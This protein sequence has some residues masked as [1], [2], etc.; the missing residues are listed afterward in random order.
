M[1]DILIKDLHYLIHF[2]KERHYLKSY[3]LKSN[4]YF[5]NL[6]EWLNFLYDN[7]TYYKTKALFENKSL[8][9]HHKLF[10][11]WDNK[12]YILG[13]T[14]HEEGWLWSNLS[15]DYYKLKQLI[16]SLTYVK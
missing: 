4:N 2:L 13:K 3:M 5:I 11:I 12:P 1:K 14:E 6:D 8:I 16:K 15:F 9:E 10:A 7:I